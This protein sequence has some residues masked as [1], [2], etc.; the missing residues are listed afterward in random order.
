ME[1]ASWVEISLTVADGELSEAVAEV[2]RRFIPDGVF[3]QATGIVYSPD[4]EGDPIGPYRVC[5]YIPNDSQLEETRSK[6]EVALWH[7][8][9]I[10]PL[11][12]PEFHNILET[13]WVDQWKQHYHP[14]SVGRRLTILP[15]WEENPRS[16]TIPILIDPGM[17][18]G[19]GT[20]P[21][22]QLSMQLMEKVFEENPPETVFD[23][24]CGSGILSIAAVKLG[25]LSAV[26]VDVDDDAIENARKNTQINNVGELISLGTGSVEEIRRGDY[27]Q[28]RADLVVANILVHILITLLDAGMAQLV[29]PGGRLILSGILAERIPEL[30]ASLDKHDLE[31]VEQKQTGD[32]VA[33][34]V[35]PAE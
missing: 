4:S 13:N 24:G 11:P 26:G 10:Q 23:I 33:F 9:R 22:T 14:I 20:H 3:I 31:I 7:L 1:Q 27:G 34:T 8:G 18:F 29:A 21:T 30:L 16:D 25:A 28:T 19:T 15:A 2:I 17:A 6:I 12:E 5:G 32:W 35:A